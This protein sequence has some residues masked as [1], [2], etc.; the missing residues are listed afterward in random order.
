MRFII[1][2]VDAVLQ[3][4]GMSTKELN[5]LFC[6]QDFAT[7]PQVSRTIGISEAQGRAYAAEIGVGRAGPSY[8]WSRDDVAEL[9]D[10]LDEEDAEADESDEELEADEG[11]TDDAEEDVEDIDEDE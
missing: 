7:T 10:L 9:L 2:I 8:I 6:D 11:D 5:R 3:P 4:I 1:A